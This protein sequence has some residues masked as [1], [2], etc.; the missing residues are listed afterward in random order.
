MYG[1]RGVRQGYRM[2]EM[3]EKVERERREI[4]V[5]GGNRG[6]LRITY[7]Q[8]MSLFQQQHRRVTTIYLTVQT[9]T[10]TPTANTVK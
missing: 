1:G 7:G 8:F 5:E 10:T 4:R 9:T 2:I 3:L 6:R